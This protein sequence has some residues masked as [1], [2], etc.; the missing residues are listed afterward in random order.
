MALRVAAL[1]R[2]RSVLTKK[3]SMDS[4]APG[5]PRVRDSAELEEHLAEN[6]LNAV[7]VETEEGWAAV[8]REREVGPYTVAKV[9]TGSPG[10]VLGKKIPEAADA[11][12]AAMQL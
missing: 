4:E 8:Y 7:L 10:N 1:P 12:A 2:R 5:V 11:V 3:A 6:W 9:P